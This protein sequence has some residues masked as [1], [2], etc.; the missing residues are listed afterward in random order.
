MIK[1]LISAL[2]QV[3]CAPVKTKEQDEADHIDTV[4]GMLE[5]NIAKCDRMQQTY[6]VQETIWEFKSVYGGHL[7]AQK[8]LYRLQA[9]LTAK[10][11]ELQK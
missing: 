11:N 3:F 6:K 2:R 4:A 1:Q 10:Q 5:T 7:R 8:H 9:K